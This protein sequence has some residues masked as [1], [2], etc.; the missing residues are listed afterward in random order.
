MRLSAYLFL[1]GSLC[2]ATAAS[3]ADVPL[4]GRFEA[5]LTAA[6]DHESPVQQV[7][8]EVEFTSPAGKTETVPG[9]WDSGRTWRARFSPGEVGR[10]TWQARC[11]EDAGLAGGKDLAESLR[12]ALATATANMLAVGPARFPPAAVEEFLPAVEVTSGHG[13]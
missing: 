10:W 3:A 11:K 2:V 13:G 7:N 12:L 8:L 5:T 1:A 4:W 6:A 9:F